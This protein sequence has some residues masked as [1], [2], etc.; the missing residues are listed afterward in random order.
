[1]PI[2]EADPWR[3][4]YF[5]GVPCPPDVRVSTEDPDSWQWYPAH[6]WIYDKL[7]VALSQGLDA[8]PHG[9]MPPSFPVFSKPIMNLRGMGTGSQVIE[10][11]AAYKAA[12][13]AGHFWC[14][15]LTGPHV[16]T[17]VALLDG[18]P[19]WWRHTTGVTAP[20][21][22]FDYWHIHA[23]AM[24]AIE[25]W[26]GDWARRHL[27]GYTGMANFETI[28]GRII[29]AHLRFADQWPDLY[30]PGWV[31]ALIRLYATGTWDYPDTGR[32]EGFS[33]VLFG[34]HGPR[35]RHPPV[36]LVEA[37]KRQPG[38]SSVQITFHED[39]EPAH[40]AM[41]PGGFRLAIV[42][43]FT[44]P[45]GRAARDQLRHALLAGPATQQG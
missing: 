14:T 29:E 36:E 27:R 43:S 35:Y 34:P 45:A 25:T 19:V 31:E 30:G 13:T 22:T 10:S 7:A 44:L 16:S 41:P 38:V 11:E 24:P 9:V 4:Q 3:F 12:L 8:A 33:V 2:C 28:G 23:E 17:D 20:G 21:G 37:I 1:M 6:R 32:G 39:K 15:L 5:D 40:H 42:N 18:Q 26:C